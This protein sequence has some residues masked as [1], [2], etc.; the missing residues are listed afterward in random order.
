MY[1]AVARAC[2]YL[3]VSQGSLRGADR[4]YHEGCNAVVFVGDCLIVLSHTLVHSFQ[5]HCTGER[6][7]EL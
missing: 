1:T 4:T 6:K 7:D 2:H 5:D 3:D